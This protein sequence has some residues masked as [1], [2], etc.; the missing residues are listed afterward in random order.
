MHA[1]QLLRILCDCMYINVVACVS[2]STPCYSIFQR[3]VCGYIFLAGE[4][5]VLNI[6][7]HLQPVKHAVWTARSLCKEIGHVLGIS[8]DTIRTIHCTNDGECLNEVLSLWIHSGKAT[9]SDLLRAL[10]N[11]TVDRNDIKNEIHILKGKA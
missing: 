9:I 5:K 10:A 7:T 6:D 11:K 8:D 2:Y 3:S 1:V 4:D